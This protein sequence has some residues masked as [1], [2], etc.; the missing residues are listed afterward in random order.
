MPSP[1]PGIGMGPLA[2][3]RQVLAVA[4]A[5]IAANLAKPANVHGYLT[6]QL[7]F[8]LH[9][10]VDMLTNSAQLRLGQ[11]AHRNARINPGALKNLLARR[12]AY[13]KDI[14]ESDVNSLFPRYVNSCDS[15]HFL[16]L[17][18]PCR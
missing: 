2:T 5:A 17:S 15:S 10:T 7:A 12:L 16:T 3:H 13:S 14:G 8:N 6:P 4:K 1:R 11:I 18:H 9:A